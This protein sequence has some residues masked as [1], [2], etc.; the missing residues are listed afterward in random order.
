ML[1]LLFIGLLLSVPMFVE[2]I[3]RALDERFPLTPESVEQFQDACIQLF[4][5]IPGE[6]WIVLWVGVVCFGAVGVRLHL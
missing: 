1:L 5:F 6:I 3:G 4:G 2:S